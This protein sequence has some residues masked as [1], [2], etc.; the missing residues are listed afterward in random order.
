MTGLECLREEMRNRGCTKA[1]TESKT[2]AIVL[3][4]LTSNGERYSNVW[5]DEQRIAWWKKALQNSEDYRQAEKKR[6][7]KIRMDIN[8]EIET[9][10]KYIDEFFEALKSC[11]T[12]EMRDRLKTAQV[13]VNT[14]NIDTK[15][16]NTAFIVGLASILSGAQ[17]NAVSELK[18]INKNLQSS[19]SQR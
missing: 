12:A 5:E 7:D 14:I 17:I 8:K 2:V 11:E 9:A 13:Y 4:I 1:Q 19:I 16:D 6:L 18:K 3:D 10:Q 15:Y